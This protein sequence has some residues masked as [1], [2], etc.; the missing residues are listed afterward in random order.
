[1]KNKDHKVLRDHKR[2]KS[3]FIPPMMQID[4]IKETSYVNNLLPHVVWMSLLVEL[5]GKR[6]GISA[7]M[8][9]IKLAHATHQSTR[10]VNFAICGNHTRLTPQEKTTVLEALEKSGELSTF[11]EALLPLLQNHPTCPMSYLNESNNSQTEPVLVR[12]L[13]DAVAAIFDRYDVG[14]SIMQANIVVGRAITGGMFLPT[15]I[16]APDFNTILS[17]PDSEAA[18]RAA[19]FAR[20]GS[21]QEVMIATEEEHKEWPREFWNRNF[22]IDNCRAKEASE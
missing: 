18:R 21:M 19:S 9:L 3:R 12:R 13:A 20:T 7:S 2:T 22:H 10:H 17:A 6:Q 16:E 1:M 15:D 11:R 14:A 8:R 4:N 5:L